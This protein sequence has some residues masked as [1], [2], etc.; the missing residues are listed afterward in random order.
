MGP[1]RCLFGTE[2]PGSGSMQNPDT[3]RSFDDLKPDIDEIAR[4]SDEDRRA[5]F[6]GNVREAF[7]RWSPR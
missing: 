3:G 6:E 2:R 7:P 4:L 1:D 5:I